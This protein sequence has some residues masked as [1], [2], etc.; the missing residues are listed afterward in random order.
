MLEPSTTQSTQ[1]FLADLFAA[2]GLPAILENEW[3]VPDSG[4]PAIRAIWHPGEHNGRLDVQILVG[5]DIVIEECFAGIG[6]GDK[7][8]SDALASFT[9]N[10]FHVLLAALWNV[11]DPEQVVKERW[12]I[13]GRSFEALIGNFGTRQSGGYDAPIPSAL[14]DL[15]AATIKHEKLTGPLHWFRFFFCN[16]AG[17]CSYEALQD[18]ATWD[19]GLH[20][21]RTAPWVRHDG[22]YSIRLFVIVRAV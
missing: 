20:C 11:Y 21:L 1:D 15:I 19:E 13:N 16:L 3:V 2:H 14:F 22:Y 5:K 7:G 9:V 17:E 8:L 6:P 18:N 10:S 12:T 4:L